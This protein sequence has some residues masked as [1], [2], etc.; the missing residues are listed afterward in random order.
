MLAVR[1]IYDG[2][3]VEILEKISIPE[4]K[5]Q[6]VIVTFLN[7]EVY[8]EP[9]DLNEFVSNWSTEEIEAI[10]QVYNA[11]SSFFNGRRFEL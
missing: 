8:L 10:N 9:F 5:L 6:E 11:R 1:G 4:G 7:E 2:K 3:K